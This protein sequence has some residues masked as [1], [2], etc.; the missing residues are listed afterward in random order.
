MGTD[1]TNPYKYWDYSCSFELIGKSP[2]KLLL[3]KV[4]TLIL[5]VRDERTDTWWILYQTDEKQCNHVVPSSYI[6]SF[7]HNILN[8][9]IVPCC[10]FYWGREYWCWT[11]AWNHIKCVLHKHD[12]KDIV[13]LLT[14]R[15]RVT[16]VCVSKLGCKWFSA[17][18][19][20]L[21]Q[22]WLIVNWALREN[23][24]KI[25]IIRNCSKLRKIHSGQGHTSLPNDFFIRIQIN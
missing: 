11:L 13:Q 16:H 25:W 15:G 3:T 21:N 20:Y 10:P 4:V 14:N 9:Q 23:V 6:K 8:E 19:H 24:T 7:P 18:S 1:S 5:C 22:C 17:P 12:S 2:V